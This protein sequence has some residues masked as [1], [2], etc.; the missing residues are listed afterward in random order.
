MDANGNWVTVTPALRGGIQVRGPDLLLPSKVMKARNE[1]AASQFAPGA[2]QSDA[3]IK[4]AE[5]RRAQELQDAKTREAEANARTAEAS[6]NG[7]IKITPEVR[8]SAL[9]QYRFAEQLNQIADDLNAQFNAG[10]GATKGLAGL[11]DYLPLT[12]NEQFDNAAN[13]SRGI[14]GQTLGFT[15]GQLNTPREAEQAIGPFLPQSSDRDP[16]AIDKINSLRTLAQNGREKA[17]QILGGEPDANGNIIPVTQGPIQSPQ[18]DPLRLAGGDKTRAQIDPTLQADGTRVGQMLVNGTPDGKI[19][20]FLRDSGVD[21]GSTNIGQALSE[22]KKPGFRQWMRANP[23]QPYPVGAE[24]YTKQVP[25]SAARR[26]FNKTAATDAGGATLAGITAAGNSFM[27][28]RLGS[29]VGAISGD[30]E[31]AQTGMQLLRTNHPVTSFLGDLAGQAALEGTV[32]RI[33]GVAPLMA[34]K[35]GRRLGDVAFGAFSGSGD[36]STDAGTGAAIGGALGGTAG[37]LGRGVQKVIGGTLTGLRDPGLQYLHSKKIPL[38]LGQIARGVGDVSDSGATTLGDEAGKGIAGLEERAA[39]LPGLEAWIKTARQ[40]GDIGFNKEAF[41]QIAPGVSGI[42]ADGLSSAKKA[43]T[44][45]YA[46]LNPARIGVEPQFQEGLDAI[47]QSAAGLS[48]HA[49]DVQSVIGDIRDQVA[50]GEMSGKGFQTALQSIR[51]TR[52]TLNDDVGGKAEAAL[53]AL[54][55]HVLDLGARQ[56]GQVAQD[57][58]EANAIHARRQIV[59]QALKGSGAQSAGERFSARDL[60]RAAIS[61]TEKFGGS[62]LALS[63]GRPFYDLT[64]NGMA[65]MPSLTPDSGTGGRMALLG[66]LGGL[67]GGIGTAIGGLTGEGGTQRASEGGGMGLAGGL[68]LGALIAAPY[69]RVGQKAIQGLLL[70][71]RPKGATRLGDFLISN[72][73][74][75]GLASQA[76]LR[77]YFLQ[78]ELPE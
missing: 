74:L 4:A 20:Q 8:A 45:A 26:N 32:G 21:P 68:T 42:G 9:Q 71:Q 76:G 12:Q 46:K 69:S 57:L 49:G 24:F 29:A 66:A 62:D 34:G 48:H 36:N 30:P 31:A 1:A 39:G 35:L 16:V 18:A 23:G 56:G 47:G 19:T 41:R 6:A 60:N 52:A 40:R 27:G 28:D 50:N 55:G 65:A 25:M 14:V 43:E 58:A 53:N 13:K 63:S 75:A 61:N 38:T 78:P 54:E 64:S 3:Q 59:K 77:D 15:G 37:M 22:R 11:K 73:R 2:A 17:I 10:P 70:G 33:P 7:K 72:P 67:G 51:K 5:A 44:A